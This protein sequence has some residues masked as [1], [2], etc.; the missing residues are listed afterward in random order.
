MLDM[1]IKKIISSIKSAEKLDE[2]TVTDAQMRSTDWSFLFQ[3]LDGWLVL[4]VQTDARGGYWIHSSLYPADQID[5][6]KATLPD[7][8]VNPPSAAY[9]H[10]SSGDD[11]WIEPFWSEQKT[12]KTSEVPFYFSSR[13]DG[14]PRGKE[15]VIEFNQLVTHSLNLSWSPRRNAFCVVNDLGEEVDKIKIVDSDEVKLVLIRR[16]ALDKLLYLGNWVLVRY[17]SFSRWR[18]LDHDFEQAQTSGIELANLD[19]KFQ[20]RETGKPISWIEFRGAVI[21]KAVTAKEKL[22]NWSFADDESADEKEFAT[23]IVQDIKNS[24]LLK[25]YSIDPSNFSNY[26]TKSELPLEV[27]P[28]FFKPEVLDKYIG[29]RDRYDVENRNI[30]CR[31][32]WSLQT[33]D[34]NDQGQVHTYAIYLS[35]LPYREQLHWKQFNEEPKGTISRTAYKTDFLAEWPDE[36][37]LKN[38]LKA[39]L[40]RLSSLEFRGTPIWKPKGGSMTEGLRSLHQL[41][42]ENS[43]HWHDFVI[44]LANA[45]NEGFQQKALIAIASKIGTVDPQARTLGLLKQIISKFAPERLAETHTFLSTLQNS[46]GMGKAH[47]EWKTPEGSLVADAK[48]KFEK[49]IEAIKSLT[50]ILETATTTLK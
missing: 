38:Q 14:H 28:V 7:F 5:T 10:V 41:R 13:Y 32:G 45:T 6:L 16:T 47:G 30:S 17:V 19:A 4:G 27:S 37:P 39:A 25:D 33:Y 50:E 11:H 35:K 36:T 8:N 2:K 42:T 26:F 3:D 49:A 9:S 24:K 44:A 15:N 29:D 20:I 48:E 46:R 31:G 34:V 18:A 22:L 23:F 40:E 43:N 1:Q 21:T 12:F